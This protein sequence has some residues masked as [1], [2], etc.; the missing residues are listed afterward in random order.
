MHADK[1]PPGTNILIVDD[2]YLS[3]FI[4]EKLIKKVM[5]EA[6]IT[7]CLNGS[8]AIDKLVEIKNQDSNLLPD[9]IFLDIT[10]PDMNGWEFLDKYAA[11]NIDPSG[12]CKIY[13]LT[14]SLHYNDISKSACYDAVKEYILKPLNCEKLKKVFQGKVGRF[15]MPGT[16]L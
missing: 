8:Y 12:K 14:S 5:K 16:L 4:C 9:Y 7:V 3:T 1:I 6:E 11:L 2:E 10:M 13:I 15:G